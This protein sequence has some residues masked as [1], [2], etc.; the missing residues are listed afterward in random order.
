[1]E[2]WYFIRGGVRVGPV[3]REQLLEL[4]RSG[5]LQPTHK[6][7]KEGSGRWLPASD[8][9][10]LFGGQPA[11]AVNA[12]MPMP[13][14]P[15]PAAP[16]AAKPAAPVK[17]PVPPAASAPATAPARPAAPAKPAA[18]VAASTSPPAVLARPPAAPPKPAAGAPAAMAPATAP[19]KAAAIPP[20]AIP[21]APAKPAAPLVSGWFYL[22]DKKKLGP[23]STSDL[24]KL[25][26]AGALKAGDMVM[27]GGQDKWRV[28]SEVP[29]L[30]PPGAAPT[31][32]APAVAAPTPAAP[33]VAAPAPVAPVAV[34][35]PAA[36]K[37]RDERD[38][39]DEDDED[40][41]DVDDEEDDEGD[42]DE[43][44]DVDE[45]LDRAAKYKSKG[46]Y[47]GAAAEYDQ[48]VKVLPDEPE[49]YNGLAWLWATC[50]DAKIRN[51]AQAVE[52]A[53]MAVE[54]ASNAESAAE[55]EEDIEDCQAL[56]I[57][58][59]E[60]LAVAQAE[61]GNFTAAI[62]TLDSFLRE[63]DPDEAPRLKQLRKQFQAK[64]PVREGAKAPSD[65]KR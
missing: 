3:A 51:G 54:L 50:P 56:R 9:P 30:F 42:E 53:R 65:S 14:R 15:Q 29:G 23:V 28:A 17:P 40:E 26:E 58:C 57:E 32:A 19:A 55:D 6:L 10:G 2:R 37:A 24:K 61:T 27:R 35:A 46:N 33:A 47:A 21:P 39:H 11:P 34:P 38:I 36:I 12:A 1:M 48:L 62:A 60:T 44:I 63:A 41:D 52:Y 16:A 13:A 49:G 18:P 25:A 31:P 45:F 64:Q 4:V 43:E 22:Q 5:E 8:T 20:A 59:Q 7:Q